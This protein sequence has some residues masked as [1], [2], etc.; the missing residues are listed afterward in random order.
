MCIIG[1]INMGKDRSM[2]IKHTKAKKEAMKEVLNDQNDFAQTSWGVTPN[3]RKWMKMKPYA[4]G[5]C[6]K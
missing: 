3:A 4:C 6:S 5:I 2:A 1:G